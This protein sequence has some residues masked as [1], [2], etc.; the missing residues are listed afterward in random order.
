MCLSSRFVRF[1]YWRRG[2]RQA[3]HA[4]ALQEASEKKY[5]NDP[6]WKEY[7]ECVLPLFVLAVSRT[8]DRVQLTLRSVAHAY[9]LSRKVP[10]FFSWPGAHI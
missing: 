7:K 1:F 3:D 8:G 9:H 2:E 5:G 4:D 10:V 6:K